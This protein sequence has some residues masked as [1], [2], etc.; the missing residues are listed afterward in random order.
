MKMLFQRINR[1]DPEKIF[2]V[3]KN[4]YSTA[5]LTNGQAVIWDYATDADGVGVTKPTDGTGRASHYGTA[6]AGVAAETIAANAYGLL[7]V[8]GYHASTRVRT[9]TGTNP[10]IAAGTGLAQLLDI[11]ALQSYPAAVLATSTLTLHNAQWCGFALEAQ[12]SYTTKA[13]KVFIKAL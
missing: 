10:A 11:F 2:I 6:F 4:S 8:Y 1:S 5:S 9:Q 3:V 7:Q 12:A 13:I